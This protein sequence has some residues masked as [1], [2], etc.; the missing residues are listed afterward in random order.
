MNSN[1]LARVVATVGILGVAGLGRSYLLWDESTN[2]DL[3]NDRLNPTNANLQLGSGQLFATTGGGDIDY[4]HIHLAPGMELDQL[5]FV[6]WVGFD[7]K[8]FIGVQAGSVFTE[9]NTN[10]NVANLLGWSHYGPVVWNDGTDILPAMGSQ[11]TIFGNDGEAEGAGAIG[12]T[13]PLTGSDY[14]F[15]LNQTSSHAVTYELDFVA[16][17][18]PA[19]LLTLA[20]GIALLSRRRRIR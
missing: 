12:F 10:T 11:G 1:Q 19:S 16:S 17:P 8:G 7:K 13:A 9:P 5:I 4:L 15:W 3:S 6:E 18:E 14:T 2:G 20:G